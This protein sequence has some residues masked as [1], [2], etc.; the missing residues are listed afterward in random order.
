MKKEVWGPCIWKTLHVLT[1]KIKDDCFIEQRK[2]LIEMIT[3]ICSH[4]PC[5]N[6]STHA[7]GIIRK[8][9]LKSVQTKDQ[10][11]RFLFLMHNEVN[12]RVKKKL[13][14]YE[15]VKTHYEKMNT[16]EVLLEYYN[17]NMSMNFGE[18]MMLYSF[19]RKNFLKKFRHYLQTHIQYFDD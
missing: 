18:K 1:V 7:Q 17:K 4:L 19:H 15:D 5:P 6:C 3:H 13:Y 2:Q 11:I 14:I 9:N 12:K 10:L 16:K 8:M